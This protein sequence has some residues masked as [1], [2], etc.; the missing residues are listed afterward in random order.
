MIRSSI[1][2]I[3]CVK[4][5]KIEVV[6]SLAKGDLTMRPT[7]TEMSVL[8]AMARDA[9]LRSATPEHH[10]FVG[11]GYD[12]TEEEVLAHLRTEGITNCGFVTYRSPSGNRFADVWVAQ[13]AQEA[14]RAA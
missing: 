10:L 11:V 8:L 4:S 13:A 7:A 14:D 12:T 2:L 3:I 5:V 6:T 1:Y 9:V